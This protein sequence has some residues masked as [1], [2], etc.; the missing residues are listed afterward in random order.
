MAFFLLEQLL[1]QNMVLKDHRC[2]EGEPRRHLQEAGCGGR[3]AG[4]LYKEPSITSRGI[5]TRDQRFIQ[6]ASL[7][8]TSN[9]S[10]LS[11]SPTFFPPRHRQPAPSSVAAM[12]APPPRC[13][14]A[15]CFACAT[16]STIRALPPPP[17]RTSNFAVRYLEF[18]IST[19]RTYNFN[20]LSVQF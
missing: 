16:C 8:S 10:F 6:I 5:Q 2:R 15:A 13:A 14:A 1:E 20:I 12:P 11:L 7:E 9:S 17:R 19:F 4:P 18:K 3:Q